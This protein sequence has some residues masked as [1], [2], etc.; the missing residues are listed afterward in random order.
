Q[1]ISKWENDLSEPDIATLR[2]LA[3]LYEVS[4]GELVDL[5]GGFPDPVDDAA[6]SPEEQVTADDTSSMRIMI[7]SDKAENVPKKNT[8][9][10]TTTLY[11]DDLASKVVDEIEN[12]EKTRKDK[13]EADRKNAREAR[14]GVIMTKSLIW[15]IVIGSII[16]IIGTVL[17]VMSL[18]ESFDVGRLFAYIGVTY[19]LSAFAFCMFFDT[20][21]KESFL[22]FATK[23]ISFPGLIFE[24][25]IDG[26]MWLIG[27]K[28]LFALIGF[29]FGVLMFFIGLAVAS[30][31]AVFTFPWL[32]FNI[33]NDSRQGKI[34]DYV[35]II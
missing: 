12:R 21:V 7:G 13:E 3:N 34:G 30:V 9:S 27:M 28:L 10:S 2:A 16:A 32:V 33:V 22:W 29:L 8:S 5:E 14:R 1:A 25:S 11:T 19:A 20:W 31:V 35:D 23:V 6:E 18:V 17:S 15:G 4:L 24:W 26:F